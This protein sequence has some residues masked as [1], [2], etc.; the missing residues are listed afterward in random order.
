MSAGSCFLESRTVTS[1]FGD[2]E[3]RAVFHDGA[4]LQSWLDVEAA[5]ARGQARL[6]IIPQAAAEEIT[7]SA[8]L[9]RLDAAAIDAGTASTVHPLVPLI[10]ALTSACSGDAG[11]YVHLGATTQDVMDTGFVLRVRAGLDVVQGQV[12][13]LIELLRLLSVRHRD[14]P[15]AAR[16]HGQQAIPTTFGLRCAVWRSELR[17]HR[18]RLAQMRARVPSSWSVWLPTISVSLSPTPHGTPPRTGSPNA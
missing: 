4:Q 10:R 2:D 18:E 12:D 6:A 8:R 13:E 17:R 16:T 11:R 5:L 1:F 7:A 3:M 14:T 15:M 9:D